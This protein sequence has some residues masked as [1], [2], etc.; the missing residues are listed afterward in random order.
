MK[1][2]P[3]EE[4]PLSRQRIWQ[5]KQKADGN[6]TRCGNKRSDRSISQCDECLDKANGRY[7]PKGK[8]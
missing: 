6:C 8:V 3:K 7:K 1:R 5:A 2:K 4:E